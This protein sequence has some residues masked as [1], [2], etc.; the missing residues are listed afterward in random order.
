MNPLIRWFGGKGNLLKKILPFI[1]HGQYI[2][3]FGGGASV[4]LNKL[5]CPSEIYNDNNGMLCNFWQVVRDYH[6]ELQVFCN[7]KGSVDSRRLFE[8]C[9]KFTGD[10][11]ENAFKFFYLNHHSQFANMRSYASFTLSLSKNCQKIFLN[12]IERIKDVHDRLK[13]VKLESKDFSKILGNYETYD[14]EYVL[15]FIDPPYFRNFKNYNQI[16]GTIPWQKSYFSKLR[17]LLFGLNKAK[18][19]LTIDDKDYFYKKGY[20]IE[21]CGSHVGIDNQIKKET[22]ESFKEYI[23]RNF[24]NSK[25]PKM[26]VKSQTS[27][28]KFANIKASI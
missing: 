27:I 24:D 5:P 13:F 8:L 23:I 16:P 19:V 18:F 26:K 20:Y 11:V 21:D 17:N 3:L 12:Q 25:V 1:V 28:E 2:E 7:K 6:C 15:F 10:K 14:K 22:K 9:K 4:L